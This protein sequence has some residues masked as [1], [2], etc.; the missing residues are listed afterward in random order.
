M[1]PQSSADN[2]L[3]AVAEATRTMPAVPEARAAMSAVSIESRSN[4]ACSSSMTTKSNPRSPRISVACAVGV[5]MKVPTSCSPEANRWR[6]ADGC[7]R[8]AGVTMMS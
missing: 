3:A 5:L 2:R 6:N 1:A 4:G 7:G 8:G